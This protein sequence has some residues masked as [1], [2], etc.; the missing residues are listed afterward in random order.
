MYESVLKMNIPLNAEETHASQ[1][2]AL[3]PLSLAQPGHVGVIVK[4]TGLPPIR[5]HL[6]DL[7]FVEGGQV[8]V[9][10]AQQG[11]LIVQVKET[12]IAMNRNLAEKIKI[13][14]IRKNPSGES[15]D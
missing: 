11:S 4:I 8:M 6:I 7:G 10:S 15:V 1:S 12:R 9:H 3:L 14:P 2:Q 5:Q 13:Q